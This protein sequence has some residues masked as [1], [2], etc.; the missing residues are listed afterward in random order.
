M[1]EK[2]SVG[3]KVRSFMKGT[4][5]IGGALDPVNP[6]QGL[7]PEDADAWA[8]KSDWE[9]VRRDIGTAIDQFQ[10]STPSAHPKK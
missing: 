1:K 8:L 10:E 7:S 3:A 5:F 2:E 4:A 6:Y 9:A